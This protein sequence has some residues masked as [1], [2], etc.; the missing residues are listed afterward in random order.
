MQNLQKNL[1]FNQYYSIYF[2]SFDVLADCISIKELLKYKNNCMIYTKIPLFIIKFTC[3]KPNVT[4]TLV[5][6]GVFQQG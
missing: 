4:T 5:V 3:D 2:F 1:S 6:Y